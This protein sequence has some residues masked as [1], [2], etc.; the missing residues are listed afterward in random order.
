LPKSFF[1]TVLVMGFAAIAQAQTPPAARTAAPPQTPQASAAPA[2]NV[3][4]PTKVAIIDIRNA[5]MATKEGS[6][7]G[8]A[9]N[10]K[11]QPKKDEFDK[12]Q[13]DVQL[14][15]DQLKKG[16]ATM[17]DDAKAKIE[18]DIDG[19]TKALQRDTQDTSTDYEEEMGK[20]Y[21]ELGNKMLEIIQQYSYQNGYAVVLDVS[22][23]QTPVIWAAPSANITA[24]I[25]KLYDQAHPGTPGAAAPKPQT[26]PKTPPSQIKK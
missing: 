21:N 5:I 17:S 26:P 16:S 25:I 8:A 7:Q 13:R 20:M 6:A 3:T 23:Q 9:V 22:N 12:R 18:R 2:G 24:D 4:L 1:T 19:K 10:L 15:Q 11:Y 14:L